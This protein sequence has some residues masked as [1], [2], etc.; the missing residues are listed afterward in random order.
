MEGFAK[1]R[2]LL[3]QPP[4]E[5]VWLRLMG[6]F[7]QWSKEATLQ[8]ALDYAKAHLKSWPDELRTAIIPK[9]NQHSGWKLAKI[10]T[11]H[12]HQL[13]LKNLSIVLLNLHNLLK[14]YS[15]YY[16]KFLLC[17]NSHFAKTLL[18]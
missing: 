17:K 9:E 3:G 5:E 8:I 10:L 11:G 15:N 18:F 13:S 4:S 1:L 14:R 12:I 2:M 6:T 16:P 7:A